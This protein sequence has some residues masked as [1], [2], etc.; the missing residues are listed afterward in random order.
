MCV[1]YMLN[2]P[3]PQ[4]QSYSAKMMSSVISILCAVLI[5]KAQFGCFFAG[6]V[7]KG[8]F[9]GGDW[10]VGIFLKEFCV[11]FLIFLL[12]MSSISV[13]MKRNEDSH[14]G[15]FAANQL[16]SHEAAFVGIEMIITPQAEL[17]ALKQDMLGF[18]PT[19][20][21]Y[22]AS[23]AGA[24]V[25]LILISCLMGFMRKRAAKAQPEMSPEALAEQPALPRPGDE[26]H[27]QAHGEQHLED[28]SGHGAHGHHKP[29]W[30]IESEEA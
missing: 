14:Y 1:V 13:I 11:N 12:W 7:I 18:Y 27:A 20:G 2:F 22:L 29:H 9:G 28:R 15:M 26:V 10:G 30:V 5:E 23:F 3:D 4:V 19:L 24:S 6:V 21:Y 16:L 25:L 8:I 17:F